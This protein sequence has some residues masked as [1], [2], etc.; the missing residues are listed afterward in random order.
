MASLISANFFCKQ[1]RK[2]KAFL[3]IDFAAALANVNRRTIYRW[4]DRGWL[5]WRAIPNGRRLICLQSLTEVRG[6]D[7]LKLESLVR[8][9]LLPVENRWKNPR[10]SATF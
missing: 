6:V 3:P 9:G 5:H 2:E 4:M 1:C 7:T 10:K 8:R